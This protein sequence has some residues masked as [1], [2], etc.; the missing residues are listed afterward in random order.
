MARLRKILLIC[1]LIIYTTSASLFGSEFSDAYSQTE[2]QVKEEVST[3]TITINGSSIIKMKDVPKTG[4][5][6]VMSVLG[7]RVTIK[8]LKDCTDGVFIDLPNGIYVLKAG[9]SSQKIVVRS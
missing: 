6:E 5:L 8:N 4:Y 7:K 9:K 1:S 3:L 2:P